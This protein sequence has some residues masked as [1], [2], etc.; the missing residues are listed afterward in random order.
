ME[1]MIGS[2]HSRQDLLK[3]FAPLSESGKAYLEVALVNPKTSKAEGR[4]FFNDV[5]FLL[6]ACTPHVGR[7][8]FCL[9][10]FA[11]APEQVPTRASCNQFDRT[12]IDGGLQESA[13]AHS[14]TAVFLFKPDLVREMQ[15]RGG[16]DHFLHIVYQLDA[17]LGR[18]G[19]KTYGMDYFLTGMVA[20][21]LPYGLLQERPMGRAALAQASRL[22]TEAIERQMQPQELKR[23]AVGSSAAGKAWDPLPGLPGLFSG[24]GQDTV[25]V[26]SSGALQPCEEA[27]FAALLEEAGD[28]KISRLRADRPAD[29]INA[30]ASNLQGLSQNWTEGSYDP[31]PGIGLRK[32]YSARKPEGTGPKRELG[33][34]GGLGGG[35]GDSELAAHLQACSQGRWRWPLFSGYF[36]KA[37]QGSACGEMLLLQCDPFASDIAFNYLMQCAETFAKEG[38]GQIAVFTKRRS[39][40]DIAL[41][42]LRRHYKA[43]PLDARHAG[44]FPDPE[45]LAKVH[46]SLFPGRPHAPACGRNE[47]LDNVLRYLEHDY[48]L[49]QRK[50]GGALM[51]LAVI[52]EDIDDFRLESDLETCK[53]L[54]AL[55]QKLR[56]VNGTLW[57]TQSRPAGSP[58]PRAY[59]GMADHLAT[60]DHDGALEAAD[61]AAPRAPRAGE[62]EAGFHLD[63]SLGK[64]VHEISLVK[65]RFQAHGS[66]RV[67]HGHYVYYRPSLLFREIHPPA[68]GRGG[69]SRAQPD[70]AAAGTGESRTAPPAGGVSAETARSAPGPASR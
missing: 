35:E 45:G 40:G 16:G 24:E 55:K 15:E 25:I 64:L 11:Y 1:S 61:A 50:T 21:F 52:V 58:A 51:P 30:Y 27:P 5:D 13:R 36:N 18:L 53:R 47:G 41:G 31:D 39:A 62:W 10:N 44:R 57:V 17:I 65:I 33:G 68:Q 46:Q 20:R 28:G 42:S 66:H 69:E 63:L 56:E 19:I 48:L 23:F 59:L 26:A 22:L 32:D 14:L 34:M 54:A 3:T 2:L 70:R 67:L 38:A 4:G 8:N 49:K 12:L 9:S 60:L 37:H 7:Y 43:D 6:E 29:A